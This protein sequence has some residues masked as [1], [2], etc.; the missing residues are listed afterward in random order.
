MVLGVVG[1]G[2]VW[3]PLAKFMGRILTQ[4]WYSSAEACSGKMIKKTPFFQGTVP[5]VISFLE[6]SCKKGLCKDDKCLAQ[7]KELLNGS[8]WREWGAG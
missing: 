1:V 2:V 5:L 4:L 8:V 3:G 6:L 7:F